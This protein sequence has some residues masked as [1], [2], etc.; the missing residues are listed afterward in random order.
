M[1]LNGGRKAQVEC[2][3]CPYTHVVEEDSGVLPG[4]I[5]IRHGRETGH[6]LYVKY[7]EE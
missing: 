4:E 3:D 5:V 2:Q 7:L 1:K 6:K